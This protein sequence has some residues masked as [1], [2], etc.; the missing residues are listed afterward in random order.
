MEMYRILRHTAFTATL[1]AIALGQV[2]QSST[3]TSNAAGEQKPDLEQSFRGILMDASCQAIQSRSTSSGNSPTSEGT[4]SRAATT[5]VGGSTS[6]TASD[7][8]AAATPA[9]AATTAAT[10]GVATDQSGQATATREKAAASAAG[11][12]SRSAHVNPNSQW[13]TVREKYKDCKVTSRTTSFALMSEGQLYMLD[14]D[15][16]SLKPQT[17]SSAA[18]DSEWRTV[19]IVGKQTGDH[20]AVTAVP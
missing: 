8:T 18:S 15:S 12:R 19:N 6:N 2:S 17:S 5:A 4:R 14:D 7:G 20:I 10:T 1:A 3:K 9:A 16:S 11:E 13:M